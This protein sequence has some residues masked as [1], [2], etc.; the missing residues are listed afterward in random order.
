[1]RRAA[2]CLAA[3][4]AGLA[5]GGCTAA[6]WDAGA[7]GERRAELAGRSVGRL[8]DATPYVMAAHGTLTFF[9]CRFE[10]AA[11]LGV[12]LPPDAS[13]DERRLVLRA[14]DAW[15]QAVPGLRFA[16]DA[17][18]A[19]IRLR[20]QSDGPEGARTAAV[21][22]VEPSRAPDG[23]GG[24][25]VLR[26]RLRSAEVML[27]RVEGDAWGRP[28]ALS[29]AEILGSLLHELGHAL[30]LQGHARRGPS[31]LVRDVD[32]VRRIG[33]R[34]LEGGALRED[35]MRALYAL[36]SGVVT[37]RRALAPG[38]TD[39]IDAL[40]R[41]ALRAGLAVLWVRVGDGSAWL[42]WGGDPDF[43]YFLRHAELL[44]RDQTS[45]EESLLG[46]AWPR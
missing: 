10:S 28:V 27:R 45:F 33:R 34:V 9:L 23:E 18:P 32:R 35:A 11:P 12:S 8:G 14:L 37:E 21:C 44:A 3:A 26:A 7:L 13:P 1:M 5:L 6:T 43:E 40:A 42:A 4:L 24:A 30:G 31:V 46:P 41:R 29:D 17:K 38:A 2:A 15:E 22:G 20:F 16:P 25:D 39:R 36:P 19:A